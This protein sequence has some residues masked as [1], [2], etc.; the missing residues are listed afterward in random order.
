MCKSLIQWI[1]WVL[2]HWDFLLG[3]SFFSCSCLYTTHGMLW[4]VHILLDAGRLLLQKMSPIKV[5]GHGVVQWHF[6][7]CQFILKFKPFILYLYHV[8]LHRLAS[9]YDCV[10]VSCVSCVSK[11]KTIT[12][13]LSRQLSLFRFFLLNLDP[14]LLLTLACWSV[15]SSSTAVCRLCEYSFE[16]WPYPTYCHQS[17]CVFWG[18]DLIVLS[19]FLLNVRQWR[20]SSAHNGHAV[21]ASWCSM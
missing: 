2:R 17:P 10:C 7:H 16:A 18:S 3:F 8:P 11:V 13:R 5:L 15:L 9:L 19:L 20:P 12:C 14:R 21:A 1:W 4:Y 6:V